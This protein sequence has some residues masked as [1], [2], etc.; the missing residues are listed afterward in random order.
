MACSS[1]RR[2]GAGLPSIS[3]HGGYRTLDLADL[4]HARIVAGRPLTEANII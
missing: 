3:L 2:S 4:G 1:R